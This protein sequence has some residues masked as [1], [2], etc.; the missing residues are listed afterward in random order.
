MVKLKNQ[1]NIDYTKWTLE[2]IHTFSIQNTL[3]EKWLIPSQEQYD[4]PDSLLCYPIAKE[5]KFS[6]ATSQSNIFKNGIWIF[7]QLIHFQKLREWVN[8]DLACYI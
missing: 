5:F 1:P 4:Y 3:I 8:K 7:R 2:C 6:Y